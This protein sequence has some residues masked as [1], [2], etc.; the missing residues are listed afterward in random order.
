VIDQRV[1]L[2]EAA[3]DGGDKQPR[4]STIPR[5]KTDDVR[6]VVDRIVKRTLPPEN[7]PDEIDRYAAGGW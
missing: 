4:K 5:R 1:D 7:R 3:E 6:I 2:A